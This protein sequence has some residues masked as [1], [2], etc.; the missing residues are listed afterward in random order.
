MGQ[1]GVAEFNYEKV[2]LILRRI[3]YAR[4]QA[5]PI[6]FHLFCFLPPGQ[7]GKLCNSS[8]NGREWQGGARGI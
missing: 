4:T 7:D 5:I 2:L 3:M 8:K 6:T 1:W